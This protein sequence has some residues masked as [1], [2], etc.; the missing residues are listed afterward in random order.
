MRVPFRVLSLP[1]GE[2][3]A[4]PVFL[5]F[6]AILRLWQKGQDISVCSLVLESSEVRVARD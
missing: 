5:S 2:I 6:I 1:I 3:F 4:P